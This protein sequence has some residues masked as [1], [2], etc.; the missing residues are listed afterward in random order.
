MKKR[1][2]DLI[3]IIAVLLCALA[4]YACA[5]NNDPPHAHAYGAW[6]GNDEYTHSRVC[7]CGSV[8]TEN[9]VFSGDEC[10]LCGFVKTS[11]TPD[12][13][14]DPNPP[15]PPD[16][17][18]DE[19]LD[20]DMSGV[21]FEN[22]EYDYDGREHVLE[23]TG[24]LP[25]GVT[26]SY[27]ENALTNAGELI[28]TASFSGDENHNEIPEM[29]AT[30][31]VN[32]IDYDMAE[33][34]FDGMTCDY[35]GGVKRLEIAGV[36]P[37]GV[38]VTYDNNDK[39]NAGTYTV[40][41]SFSGD[42]NH[43][44]IP[45]MTA[46]LTVNK[47]D[48]D[49]AE[50]VFDGM[51]CDY[52]GGV[53]RLEIAGV[54]PDGVT[55]TY[56]NNDKVNAGTY[57]VTASF[58]GDEN[59]NDIPEMTATLTVNKI[60]YDMSGVAFED[61]TYS[62]DGIAKIL[63]VTGTLPNGLKVVYSPNL[64]L[65]E[66][67]L[68]VT[69]AFVA[70]GNHNSVAPMTATLKVVRDGKYHDAVFF[71]SDNKAVL[72]VV[73]HG[74][75]VTDIPE[76]PNKDGY[77]A[78]WNAELSAVTEDITVKPA[79]TPIVYTVTYECGVGANSPE[80]P[81]EYTV[82]SPIISLKDATYKVGYDFDGWYTT[83]DFQVG[84]KVDSIETGT[85]GNIT[86]YAKFAPEKYT[87]MYIYA[88]RIVKAETVEYGAEYTFLD[89]APLPDYEVMEWTDEN[90]N[91]YAPGATTEYTYLQGMT[92]SGEAAYAGSD[93]ECGVADGTATITKYVGTATDVVIPEYIKHEA[94]YY[95]V[96]AI[97][98]RAFYINKNIEKV[99]V[100]RTVESIGNEVFYTCTALTSVD[101]P[102]GVTSIGHHAFENCGSL[103]DI[104]VPNGVAEIDW[105]T[106]DG[107]ARL[108]RIVL[109]ESVTVIGEAAFSGCSELVSVEIKGELTSIGQQAFSGCLKLS[110][111]S[112]P[113]SVTIIDDRAFMACE[114]LT[115]ITI[116]GGVTHFGYS[117]FWK[118]KSLANVVISQGVN[119]IGS[120]TFNECVMLKSI[121]IP[122]SVT[123]IGTAVFRECVGLANVSLGN[124]ITEI[125]GSAFYNCKSL[126]SIAI[127]KGVSSVRS[128]IFRGCKALASITV[129]RGNSVYHSAGNCMIETATKTLVVGCKNSV[130]PD[131][132][133]VTAIGGN[134][135]YDSGLENI[136]IPSSV[137]TIGNYAFYNCEGLENIIIP[138]SVK[139]IGSNAFCLC[140]G[141]TSVVIEEGVT[142]IGDQAFRNCS[143]IVNITLP[144][145]LESIKNDTF[146]SCRELKSI[147]IP[148]G[149]SSIEKGAFEYCKS[150]ESIIVDSENPVYH[151]AGNCIIETATKTLVVGCKNSVI[152]DDGSVAVIGER[153]FYGS[154]LKNIIIPSSVKTIGNYA[155]EACL[156][157]I[158]V[159]ISDGVTSIG[160][161]AFDSCR[162]LTNIVI[163]NGVTSIG[164]SAF[165]D[166]DSIVS[167]VIPNSV[168]SIGKS[169][170]DWT[171]KLSA[172]YYKGTAEEWSN[173]SIGTDND[174]LDAATK[175]FYSETN[176]YLDDPA[177]V[178]R[179]WHYVDDEIVVWSR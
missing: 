139:T 1:L 107:C 53:K 42:E 160:A 173:I 131:D 178:N 86:L 67:E 71:L 70:D 113:E 19:K 170:F 154:G 8:A 133:S 77:T 114:S 132:G 151:S 147:Y 34:V 4:L 37:D 165:R 134:A 83:N 17:P 36:L 119:A 79:Y 54:L 99:S 30:L 7:D 152:P 137:N 76:V 87:V 75:G 82:E 138:S 172:V 29:T 110:D 176:P 162:S 120:G 55:V 69:A 124:G 18:D 103:S 66:G 121:I 32:K 93:F 57:T 127:P 44:E 150:L 118:C 166:C 156:D 51:T 21:T 135:F 73:K 5:N 122:D 140:S 68:T 33:I 101:I 111:I 159:V 39:V 49:M 174:E 46:T 96:T 50:I 146:G 41:A 40:T 95:T 10:A 143:N 169:L 80:N 155:F 56:D 52:D 89:H 126:E 157:L 158:N 15:D 112:L 9:H 23:I 64:L 72:R 108:E 59:H 91:K 74:E 98:D 6:T 179:Y 81:V 11:E 123:K 117:V 104:T 47:I 20:Y 25:D 116:P 177:D 35:D 125:G 92:L 100:A 60:D 38:T 130:I 141:L 12:P 48:Y 31:T 90:G 13:P 27:T 14:D 115:S 168:T 109:P 145:T 171:Y 26:V 28:V 3:S 148:F 88:D 94:A 164:N 63:E 61:A 153:A 85:I 22:A 136:I 163:P 161:C 175:Y 167:I 149:V 65:G 129:D 24:A 43:N 105:C 102:D 62:Y 106:F 16:P 45:E 2:T 144:N 97:G 142:S 78:V 58:S 84:S 128:N